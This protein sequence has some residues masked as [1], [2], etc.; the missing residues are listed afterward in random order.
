MGQATRGVVELEEIK[1]FD[2]VV[3]QFDPVR[4]RTVGGLIVSH[5]PPINE[6]GRSVEGGTVKPRDA[7]GSEHATDPGNDFVVSVV[8]LPEKGLGPAHDAHF[9]ELQGGNELGG[10][11]PPSIID[12]YV[13]TLGVTEVIELPKEDHHAPLILQLV[14]RIPVGKN[15]VILGE[16]GAVLR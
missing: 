14:G 9:V 4:P 16:R 15:E 12:P 13:L 6:L 10:S 3:R 2:D 8:H 1:D 7:G 11:V 5:V